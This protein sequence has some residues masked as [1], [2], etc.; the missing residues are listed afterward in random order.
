MTTDSKKTHDTI[1]YDSRCYFN[2]QLKADISQLNRNQ[3]LRSEKG[4]LKKKNEYA[5]KY[6]QSVWG[7]YGVSPEEEKEGYSE[8]ALQKRKV[9]SRSVR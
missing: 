4:E 9:L 8:K 3:K 1:R 2:A 6:R 5:H 7:I